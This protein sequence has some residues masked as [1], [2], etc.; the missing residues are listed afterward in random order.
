MVLQEN[1]VFLN[2]IDFSTEKITQ[3]DLSKT[4]IYS[5]N[6]KVHQYLESLSIPHKIAEDILDETD[7]NLIFDKTVSSYRWYEHHLISQKLQFN[8]TNILGMMDDAEFHTFLIIKLYEIRIIQKILKNK[9]PNRIY[10]NKEIINFIKKIIHKK[11]EFVEIRTSIKETMVYNKIEIKFNLGKIPFSFKISRNYY[12]KI[13]SIIENIV[14]TSNNLWVDMSKLQESILLLEINPSVY[15]ELLLELSK[16]DKQVVLLNNRRSA[17]WNFNSISILKK[18]KSKVLSLD[19]ILNKKELQNIY[20]HEFKFQKILDDILTDERMSELFLIDKITF[21]DEIKFE[22]INTF[23]HRLQWYMK[24]VS[25]SK[26]FIANSNIHSVLSLN[27]IGETEKSILNQISKP[28]NS[29]MLEHAFANYTDEISRYDILS[30]YTIFPDKIAVWG[31]VQKNY[32][33]N[34]HNIFDDKI[35]ICGSP[36]HD[37]FFKLSSTSITSKE[38]II[39]LCPRPIVEV[40]ARHHTRMYIKYEYNLRKIISELNKIKNCKLIVKLHPGNI[41]HNNLIKNIINEINPNIIVFHT[42]SIDELIIKSNLVLVISPDGFDP[43]TVILESIILQKPIINFILDEKFY[44]FSFEQH[45]AVISITENDDMKEIIL[46]VLNDS[47]FRTNL[48]SNG[49]IFLNDYLSNHQHAA[50][51]LVTKLLKL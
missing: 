19:H 17:I 22:L 15:S 37:S 4:S 32:L 40:A 14:C 35:I 46:N 5:M 50:K 29:V 33:L 24:L 7:L 43:S 10:A 9:V 18:S 3:L 49:K 38:K 45:N 47:K 11:T 36:R 27:A 12:L 1:Y 2:D 41:D 21:W 20:S 6:F 23:K 34:T 8:D 25:A 42:K 31:N 39:L 16:T 26:K 28:T 13:K 30:N 44:N 51:T 48:I